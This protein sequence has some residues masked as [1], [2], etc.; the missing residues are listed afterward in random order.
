MLKVNA[1]MTDQF[2]KSNT[3]T[4]YTIGSTMGNTVSCGKKKAEQQGKW[5]FA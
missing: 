5:L 3:I 1:D 4:C 2:E